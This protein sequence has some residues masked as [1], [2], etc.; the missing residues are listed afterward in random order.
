MATKPVV[1]PRFERARGGTLDGPGRV[2]VMIRLMEP[3]GKVV[4][5]SV[6]RTITLASARVSE[7][8]QVIESALFGQE[9][10]G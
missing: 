1:K 10:T 3:N 2:V 6:S 5:G 8:I 9:A 7:V 4:K